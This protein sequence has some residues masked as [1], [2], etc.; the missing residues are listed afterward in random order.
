MSAETQKGKDSKTAIIHAAHSLFLEQGFHGTS[1]RQI[2]K[3]AEIALGGIYNYFSG[4]EEIFEAVLFEFHPY[5]YILPAMEAIEDKC[6]TEIIECTAQLI[7][8]SLSKDQDYFNLFFIELVEFG[9]VHLS[10][11]ASTIYP[12]TFP[13]IQHLTESTD[14][15][16]PTS[17]PILFRSFLI[18]IFGYIL[19]EKLIMPGMAS[20]FPDD[21]FDQLANV[22][23]H[24]ILKKRDS[25]L[26][27][28]I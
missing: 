3:H 22:F 20:H 13:F 7:I 18:F 8:Q 14:E 27:K 9:G 15:L 24:G 12:Q 26:K 6:A 1:M 21:D 19:T 2:A 28:R 10:Q 11:L 17:L 16:R 5:H 23:L 25:N 4:K